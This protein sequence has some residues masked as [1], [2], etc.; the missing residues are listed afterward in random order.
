[1][2]GPTLCIEEVFVLAID[3]D[4]DDDD[5]GYRIKGPREEGVMT[6]GL[7]EVPLPPE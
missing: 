2:V 4:D 7:N 5:D 1:M 3:D 6:A